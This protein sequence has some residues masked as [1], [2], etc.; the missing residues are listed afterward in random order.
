MITFSEAQILGWLSALLM[1]LFRLLGLFTSAPLLSSRSIPVRYRVLAAGCL[2]L[3]ATPLA[4]QPAPS[5]TDPD[6]PAL[7]AAEVMIGLSIGLVCRMLLASVEMAGEIIG[8]QMGFSFAAFFDPSTS[9]NA[10]AVGRLFNAL[11]MTTF[12]VI[13]GPLL[14]VAATM[15]SIERL[16]VSAGVQQ[17]MARLDIGAVISQVF[18]LGLLMALPY[19]TLLLFVNLSLGLISRVAPQLNVFAIGFPITIGSGLL[20]LTMGLP[21]LYAPLAQVHQAI[22]SVL[23]F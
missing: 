15:T 20:L 3:L 19:M 23:G 5:F 21:M 18:E 10:N 7:L 9:S 22:F 16:P 2:A 1:P 11:S 13:N 17:F 6:F 14:L 8:L 12:A 4:Q